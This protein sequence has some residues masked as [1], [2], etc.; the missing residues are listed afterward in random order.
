MLQLENINISLMGDHIVEGFNFQLN[1]GEIAGLFGPS[2]CGK[3]TI[4]R[5]IAGIIDIEAGRITNRFAR[6]AYL[7]QE[8]R[9]LPWRTAWENIALV[10][11][12]HHHER[13]AELL[14]RLDLTRRDWQKY[15]HELSGGMRQRIGLARALITEPDLLLMDEPFSAL[16]FELTQT[17]Q[18]LIL[19]RVREQ[20]MSVIL[21]THDR[22]EALRMAD[23]LYLLSE[24]KP[25]H[26]QHTIAL[27][28]PQSSRDADFIER[29]LTPE[30]WSVA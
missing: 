15:P 7:F 23:K 5:A 29:R 9:L 12:T 19:A 2:G 4:L 8:H 25:T 24:H 3:T 28:T 17:L 26:C 6:T 27:E 16:D 10:N 1:G 20:N 13:I 11:K 18:S 21:I 14:T 30:F 22:Y